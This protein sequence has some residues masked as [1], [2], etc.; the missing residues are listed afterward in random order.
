MAK[1]L[2][3]KRA[4]QQVVT[5]DTV[6]PAVAV[7]GNTL[8]LADL[9]SAFPGRSQNLVA[10][11]LG[12]PYMLYRTAA[13][14]IKLSK[15]TAG[16]WADVV[17]FGAVATGSGNLTPTGLVIVRNTLVAIYALSASVGIDGL[18]ARKSTDGATWSAA[19]SILN[20]LL[21][22]PGTTQGG[23]VVSWRNA[24]W[25]TGVAGIAY[26]DPVGD[27]FGAAFDTGSDVDILDQKV[28]FGAF[29]SYNDSLYY[30]L[31]TT[32]ALQ[33]PKLYKLD[34][35]WTVAVP[36]ATPAWTKVVV[37]IASAGPLFVGPDN[38]TYT[39][40]TNKAGALTAWFSG[41]NETKVITFVSTTT[42]LTS[43]DVTN[44]TLDLT[45]R[46]IVNA[47]W[48]FMADDRRR[49]NERQTL[50]CRDIAASPQKVHVLTW[51]GASPATL[52]ETFEMLDLIFTNDERGDFR[53]FTDL[54]P[55]AF[56]TAFTQPFPG[57]VQLNYT[58][59]DSLSR[60]VDISGEYSL[61]KQTWLPMTQG[62]GDSGA[63][64]LVS[65]PVGSPYF[66]YWDAFQDLVDDYD[67]ID[68]RIIVR[69]SGP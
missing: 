23:H 8:A 30:L 28:T 4:T 34:P 52:D 59:R 29:A 46:S 69:V 36:T 38:G 24:V 53:I 2:A 41:N 57:R 9:T 32:S 27:T 67:Y 25:V 50:V 62:D 43:T 18:L 12:D 66:Y 63:T 14:T 37:P 39:L 13:N 21:Y 31:P 45:V 58:V 20:P 54:L 65:T 44:T 16:V 40:F 19:V 5:L 33:T 3:Y 7:I 17:G 10:T 51:D 55:G 60:P 1:L 48:C 35:A 11:F 61:D 47:G 6:Q 22:Q 15:Y 42:G 26:Y 56:I 49:T 64:A 68:V